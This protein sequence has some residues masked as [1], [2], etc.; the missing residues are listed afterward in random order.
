MNLN[1]SKEN[2]EEILKIDPEIVAIHW[3]EALF[4][5]SVN[6][7]LWSQNAEVREKH[8]HLV[9]EYMGMPC[10]EDTFEGDYF[11]RKKW[12]GT[13]RK[14]K[15]SAL[16]LYYKDSDALRWGTMRTIPYF[17]N[18]LLKDYVG[19]KAELIKSRILKVD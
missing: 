3:P 18:T 9:E 16:W 13:Y 4:F 6:K 8:I 19:N 12:R 1:H 11:A 7:A 14:G 17:C 2:I 15:Q 5:G 10:I